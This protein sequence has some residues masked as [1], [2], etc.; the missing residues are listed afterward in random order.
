M[1]ARGVGRGGECKTK[2]EDHRHHEQACFPQVVYSIVK[3]TI[4]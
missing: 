1:P 3:K 2:K 4:R